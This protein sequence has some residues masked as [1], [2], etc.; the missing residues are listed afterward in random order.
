MC[1]VLI[2]GWDATVNHESMVA[3]GVVGIA[4]CTVFICHHQSCVHFRTV[5]IVQRIGRVHPETNNDNA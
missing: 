2:G 3:A 5:A 4:T 1:S